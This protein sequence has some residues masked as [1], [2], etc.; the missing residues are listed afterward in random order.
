MYAVD[1]SP[2]EDIT[3]LDVALYIFLGKK[4]KG[5]IQVFYVDKCDYSTAVQTILDEPNKLTTL[6]S[7]KDIDITMYNRI[8]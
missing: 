4:I 2:N 7:I 1:F 3:N 6:D 5:K 8:Q